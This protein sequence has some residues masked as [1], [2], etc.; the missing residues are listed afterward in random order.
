MIVIA[1]EN[2][3]QLSECS[4]QKDLGE[5]QYL[6]GE[7]GAEELV[8]R[9]I[10]VSRNVLGPRS[11]GTLTAELLLARVL[12]HRGDAA[13]A[14]RVV[15]GI[16]QAQAEARAAGQTDAELAPGEE[17]LVET[18]GL[19]GAPP[20]EAR[21]TDVLARAQR[22]TLQPQDVIE[23]ME[24]QALSLWRAGEVDKGRAV[25]DATMAEAGKSAEVMLMRLRRSR[26][27]LS[28]GPSHAGQ[29]A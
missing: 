26:E 18:I 16:R 9:A 24:L 7:A 8:R 14:A 20:D 28:D 5:V 23:M 21:W 3:L 1:R 19:A 15:A 12:A 10:E 6:L 27:A 22:L 29:V 13:G 25:L 11:R 4:A 2:G 17:L